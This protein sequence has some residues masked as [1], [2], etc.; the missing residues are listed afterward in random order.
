MQFIPLAQSQ[1][2][3]AGS[4]MNGMM[5][6]GQF[7]LEAK[8]T[9][10]RQQLLQSQIGV[11]ATNQQLAQTKLA[12][13]QF[14]EKEYENPTNVSLRQ[15]TAQAALANDQQVLA[16]NQLGLKQDQL[17][18][19]EYSSPEAT[20]ARS[21]TIK[22]QLA[23]QASQIAGQ[24]L[25]N[26]QGEYAFSE[27]K[28][29]APYR[30]Q[31]LKQGLAAGGIKNQEDQFTP[32]RAKVEAKQTDDLHNAFIAIG[33]HLAQE[34]YP[35]NP[36]MQKQMAPMLSQQAMVT[37]HQTAD[38]VQQTSLQNAALKQGLLQTKAAGTM[39]LFQ[40]IAGMGKT[41]LQAILGSGGFDDQPQLKKF[42]QNVVEK[43]QDS[44][45]DIQD[46]VLNAIRET[47]PELLPGLVEPG[48]QRADQAFAQTDL[49][50][51]P[52][53]FPSAKVGAAYAAAQETRKKKA[54]A[55]GGQP[56][57]QASVPAQATT[58]V[59]AQAAN[60]AKAPPALSAT[61]QKLPPEVQ[62]SLAPDLRSFEPQP[63]QKVFP[64]KTTAA[65]VDQLQ[66]VFAN[67]PDPN[68]PMLKNY[69]L[70]FDQKYK[71][72]PTQRAYLAQLLR[73]TLV[74][75]TS[76]QGG[77]MDNLAKALGS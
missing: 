7:M 29:N 50:A 21:Q 71:P 31:A 16:R 70:E 28:A 6:L 19:Q 37:A 66:Q 48:L 44:A 76:G 18:F 8:Q 43:G 54:L 57:P 53:D 1:G 17:Q 69:A 9:A 77:F 4:I 60:A 11:E 10:L 32:D 22:N 33:Q 12:A 24:N 25:Q 62:N 30:Q 35:N 13:A 59:V 5:Q 68:S 65:A 64:D 67:A 20:S 52:S 2:S 56:P 39:Q 38:Q 51:A 55:G 46:D 75:K 27:Q 42:A 63:T 36:V 74:T 23:S 34:Q 14:A 49:K 73:W 61:N 72:T 45:K 58:S 3:S 47:S 41:K 40:Q 15:Q 26:A